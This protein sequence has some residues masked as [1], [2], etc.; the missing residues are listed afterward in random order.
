MKRY[1]DIILI[2]PRN[3]ILFLKRSFLSNLYPGKY[4]LPGGHVDEGESFKEAA[5][6]ELH[7]ETNIMAC[8]LDEIGEL[9][10]EYFHI[11]YFVNWVS[12]EDEIFPIL[13]ASE[14]TNVCWICLDYLDRYDIPQDLIEK[15]KE[16]FFISKSDTFTYQA[17]I[18][19]SL[20]GIVKEQEKLIRATDN[21]STKEYATDLGFSKEEIEECKIILSK[22]FYKSCKKSKELFAGAIEYGVGYDKIAKAV[23]EDNALN[24][25]LGR[26]GEDYVK[27]QPG[28]V[29]DDSSKKDIKLKEGSKYK[30]K[31]G[32]EG[33]FVG[34]KDG[35]YMFETMSKDGKAQELTY[36]TSQITDIFA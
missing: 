35:K 30:L 36:T 19:E 24:R 18:P 9:K 8:N 28:K 6:R 29:K 2:T 21:F 33:V 10:N 26:V 1:S 27:K 15:L 11:K 16:I 4:M 7:E 31:D 34:K 23:Y 32:K 12:S 5:Y 3:K 13:D 20:E 22:S 25:R 17:L 14:H